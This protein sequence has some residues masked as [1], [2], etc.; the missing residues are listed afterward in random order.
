MKRMVWAAAWLGLGIAISLTRAQNPPAEQYVDASAMIREVKQSQDWLTK[1]QSFRVKFETESLSYARPTTAPADQAA[2]RVASPQPT[3][4]RSMGAA[5]WAFDQTRLYQSSQSP[6]LPI[7][8]VRFWDGTTA[9]YQGREGFYELTDSVDN[10]A[11][12]F[13]TNGTWG[14]NGQ[15]YW[16]TKDRPRQDDFMGAPEQYRSAGREMFKGVDCYVLEGGQLNSKIYAGAVDHR[17]YGT[18]RARTVSWFSDYKEVAPGCWYPM[19]QGDDNYSPINRPQNG[20][21]SLSDPS[22]LSQTTIK[23]VVEI[24]VNLPLPEELFKPALKKGMRIHEERAGVSRD[25]VYDPDRTPEDEAEMQADVARRALFG[26]PPLP[27]G[28]VSLGS[29]VDPLPL[30]PLALN[31]AAE[32]PAGAKWLNGNPIKLADLRGKVVII[33]FWARWAEFTGGSWGNTPMV[34]DL[35]PLESVKKDVVVVGVH[36]PTKAMEKVEQSM[37]ELH[38]DFPV[39]IDVPVE[40]GGWG[41]MAEQYRLDET[42]TTYVI[43]Q[44]GKIASLG[45]WPQAVKWTGELLGKPLS[46]PTTQGRPQ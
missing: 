19:T 9:G 38:I 42:P 31:P 1:V 16:W 6:F 46:V 12:S 21:S 34:P 2:Q 28:P 43:D 10:T 40:R 20:S 3:T 17:L 41:K 7:P 29:P 27:P 22:Y 4:R 45:T 33:V 14:R 37:K 44:D 15:V 25:Y 23:R 26:P 5:E 30:N 24:T 39:C 32:F 13:M 8:N 36:V 35:K 18:T 11:R